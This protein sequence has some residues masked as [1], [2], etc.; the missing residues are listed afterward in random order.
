MYA[1]NVALD[2]PAKP[3]ITKSSTMQCV[4]LLPKRFQ[5]YYEAPHGNEL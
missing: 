5:H 1:Q 3:K 2:I 4:V